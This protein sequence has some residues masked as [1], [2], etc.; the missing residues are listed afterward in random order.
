MPKTYIV[1]VERRISSIKT[2]TITADSPEE[3]TSLALHDAA[4]LGFPAE[5]E[6]FHIMFVGEA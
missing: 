6:Q 2:L 3:A 5:K 4:Y 1:D